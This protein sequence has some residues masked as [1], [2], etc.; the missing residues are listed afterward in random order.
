[1]SILSYLHMR[2]LTKPFAFLVKSAEGI[3]ILTGLYLPH[4]SYLLRSWL[5]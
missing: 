3:V 4:D 1:M 5:S 2:M